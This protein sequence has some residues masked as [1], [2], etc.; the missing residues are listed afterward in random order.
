V[1]GRALDRSPDPNPR[2]PL[3]PRWCVSPGTV[4]DAE[5]LGRRCSLLVRVGY[6]LGSTEK[7]TGRSARGPSERHACSP[8]EVIHS[9]WSRPTVPSPCSSHQPARWS[10]SP[11]GRS[12]R[13]RWRSPDRAGI[14]RLSPR[15]PS[16]ATRRWPI[17]ASAARPRAGRAA[18]RP[19][20]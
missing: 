5:A 9:R 10:W 3:A 17:R 11:G 1:G 14:R 13:R 15:D 18:S 4:D 19:P 8:P 2:Q 20:G 7:R 12:R 6:G 16:P